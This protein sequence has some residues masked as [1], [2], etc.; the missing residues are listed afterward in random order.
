MFYM[1]DIL[2]TQCAL[3]NKMIELNLVNNAIAACYSVVVVFSVLHICF[4]FIIL[5]N[6]YAVSFLI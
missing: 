3:S 5:Y 6:N 1:S 4:P 2:Y